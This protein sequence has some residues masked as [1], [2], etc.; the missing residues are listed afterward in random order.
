[1]RIAIMGDSRTTYSP[2]STLY[3]GYLVQS[4]PKDKFFFSQDK[5]TWFTTLYNHLE[6]VVF[7]A[8]KHGNFD[9]AILE[10]GYHDLVCPWNRSFFNFVESLD[11]KWADH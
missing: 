7:E 1:M 10:I 6:D 2:G 9:V 8:K 11:P 5:R 4:R 3:S